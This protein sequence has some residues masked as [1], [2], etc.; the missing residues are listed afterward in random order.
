VSRTENGAIV[1][2]SVNGG[3]TFTP[4]TGGSFTL[5]EGIYAAGQIKVKQTIAGIDSTTASLGALTVDSSVANP[6]IALEVDT[7]SSATDGITNN[8]I[9]NV[10]GL[11]N[12][13]TWQYSVNA[14][15]FQNGTGT[16]FSLPADLAYEGGENPDIIVRQTDIAGNES[17]VDGIYGSNSNTWTLDT[18][19]PIKLANININDTGI[20]ADFVTT[21]GTVTVNDIEIGAKLWYSID[22]AVTFTQAT[23]N[24]FVV[25]EG[26]YDVEKI[27]IKQ[28]DAAGNVSESTQSPFKLVVVDNNLPTFNVSGNATA[29]EGNNTNFVVNLSNRAEGDYSVKITLTGLGGATSAT[30]FVNT[31]TLDTASSD[32]G[33][34]FNPITGILNIPVTS[35]V[36]TATLSTLIQGDTISPETGEKVELSLSDAIGS[37][38]SIN[39]AASVAITSIID[40]STSATITASITASGSSDAS[41]GNVAFNFAAGNYAYTISGFSNGDVLNFPD[42]VEATISENSIEGDG[43]MEV[44]WAENGNVITVI[45][46]GLTSDNAYSLKSFNTEFGAGSII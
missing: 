26:T 8:N 19:A 1:S 4:L 5:P 28:I 44:Q 42:D 2:Y 29:I 39:P 11:E 13:A 30:D 9:V 12:G 16:T 33:I 35:Q 6:S 20:D 17:D 31:L 23:S 45:L 41:Q 36:T 37:N 46:T 21:D 25:P 40:Q 7:G 3:E 10:T 15:P 24:T 14:L 22:G 34:T 18:V 32:A 27:V 43:N 38:V